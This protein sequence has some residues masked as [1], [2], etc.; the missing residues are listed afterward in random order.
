M[1]S[2]WIQSPDHVID[3]ITEERQRD[4]KLRILG[5]EHSP[6]ICPGQSMSTRIIQNQQPVVPRHKIISQ[7]LGI[8]N[9]CKNDDT[10]I[11]NTS[12]HIGNS[13]I[14]FNSLSCA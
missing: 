1:I 10:D 5:A 3:L 6:N 12:S 9:T 8:D 11:R 14:I 7:R 4:I 13:T 2:Q